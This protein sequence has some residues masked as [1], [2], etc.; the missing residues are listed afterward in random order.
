MR[1]RVFVPSFLYA[2]A[3]V[4]A[5][6]LGLASVA[7]A[8]EPAPQWALDAAKIPTPANA[9]DAAAVVLSDT[10]VITV[11]S[12]N[13][14]VEQSRYAVRILQPEGRSYAH[15]YAEYDVDL[16]LDY[17]RS[18]TI[19]PGGRQF[20]AMKTDF[21]DSG[22]YDAPILQFT[23]RI[24]TVIPPGADPGAVVVCETEQHL[25]PYMSSEF[26]QIQLPI[27]VVEESLDL[28]L[29]SGGHYADSWSRYAPVK[30]VEVG[31]GDLRWEIKNMPALDL[32]NLR[33]T[34][35]LE[36]LAARTDVMWGS[37][38]AQ[39]VANQWRAIGEWQDQLEAGR[40]DPTPEITAAAQQLVAGAPDFYTKLSRITEYIQKNIRYFIVVTGIGG[41]Q[42]HY[43][44]E[45]FRNRYGDCKDKT[46][47][48]IAMLKAV[49]I[50]AYYL[51]VDSERGVINPAAPSLVGDHMVTAIELP[52][53][54]NDPRLMARVKAVTGKTLLIFDP[55]DEET[56][57]GL[58]RG[59]LQGA[60]GNLADG[61]NS[62]V[63]EMPVL[64]PDSAGIDRTG[65]FVLAAD[66]TLTG[67]DTSVFTGGEAANERYFLKDNDS[68][69]VRRQME[70]SLSADLPGLTLKD[71][72]FQ[73]AGGLNQPLTLSL[74]LSAANYLHSAG[75]L[76][77]VRPRVFGSD[78]RAVPDASQTAKH[79]YPI[80][81]GYPGRWRSSFDITLP[82][83]YAAVDTPDA[84]NVD[85]GFASYRSATTIK[86]NV[87]HYA[88]EYI[89]RQVEIPD[90]EAANLR[91]LE[92]AIIEDEQGAAVLKKQ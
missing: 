35:P 44:S 3:G 53:G 76:I 73:Q 77:L 31:P 66:G 1:L 37:T 10:R 38:A 80:E 2:A 24:R 57:V 30:P 34:P 81:I 90:T 75:S 14:A 67:T 43:A 56:P 45:I 83:G 17:L 49:G 62:Q 23:E 9:G 54:E 91:K 5:A 39:G 78:A 42:A 85:V 16:K 18:W 86:G 61:A 4:G 41:W 15:C 46:T 71:Y 74:H 28:I 26:W 70:T 82:P 55:T 29:P 58:I 59:Q 87:L 6:F 20:Q 12:D 84:V 60:Y 52:E 32:E 64:P 40:A 50:R 33:A 19:A 21:I 36:A 63:L 13:R 51:D 89:V 22:A 72:A 48:L 65:S 92:G 27:P 68:N 88:R 47:L 8:K 7:A 25:R 69:D 11:D 79:S